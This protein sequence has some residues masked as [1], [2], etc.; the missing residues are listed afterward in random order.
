[1]KPGYMWSELLTG[2]H[3]STDVAVSNGK[4]KWMKHTRGV[5][6]EQGTFDYW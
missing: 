4:V 1:M 3:Y 2:E 5:P 6:L